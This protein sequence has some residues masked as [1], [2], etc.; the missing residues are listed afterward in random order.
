MLGL[1]SETGSILDSYKRYLRDSIDLTLNREFL[2]VELGDLLW[3]IAVVAAG[4]NLGFAQIAK[5]NL[6]NVR[7]R[8]DIKFQGRAAKIGCYT[9]SETTIRTDIVA[10]FS[11]YQF[12]ASQFSELNLHGPDGLIA[13][14]CGL[15]G[16]TGTILEKLKEESGSHDLRVHRDFFRKELGD[17]LW[18]LSAVATASSLNLGDIA[19]ENLA[20]ACDL[21]PL[22]T[23]PLT[24]LFKTLSSLDDP[25]EPTECFPRQ[26]VIG[27]EEHPS[28]DGPPVAKQTITYVAPNAFPKGP[29]KIRGKLQGFKIDAPLGDQTTDNSRRADGYRYHDAI[30]MGFMAV[31]GWSPTMRMLL[32]LKRRSKIATDRDEDGARAIYTEEGL[33]AILA[34]LAPRRMGFLGENAVDG[35]IIATAQALVRD[36]EAQALPGWLWRRAISQG[37]I[38]MHNLDQNKGGY[39]TIDLDER[40]VTYAKVRPD[41]ATRKRR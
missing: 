3:Y 13:P 11:D 16:A 10:D 36:T 32:R 6:Q 28:F 12:K 26:M 19:Q 18:Y 27:F 17:L 31:L 35:E 9:P 37:F 30:H 25:S 20:R 34:R 4:C 41:V 22:S 24:E 40:E 2:R 39:L 23:E 7:T 8:Y 1:A 21:Y 14:L 33:A 15:A 38:A 29:Q 5:T